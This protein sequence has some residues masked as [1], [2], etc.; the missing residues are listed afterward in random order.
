MTAKTPCC[1]RG[2]INLDYFGEAYAY[3]STRKLLWRDRLNKTGFIHFNPMGYDYHVLT[4]MNDLGPLMHTFACLILGL[5]HR[6]CC[7]VTANPHQQGMYR[8][9]IIL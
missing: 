4:I 5:S 6:K 2:K 7:P 1:I 3:F 9:P 8:R